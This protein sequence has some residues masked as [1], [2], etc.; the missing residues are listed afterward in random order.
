MFNFIMFNFIMFNFIMFT[1][2]I[3]D[4]LLQTYYGSNT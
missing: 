3:S 4:I 1:A 2:V